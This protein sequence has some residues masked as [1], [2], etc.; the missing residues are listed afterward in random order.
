MVGCECCVR[1][2]I[3][4]RGRVGCEE[5]AEETVEGRDDE[6]VASTDACA[7]GAEDSLVETGEAGEE[8]GAPR[9]GDASL[10]CV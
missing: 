5:A 3:G 9:F 4:G 2:W 7:V 8:V 6:M 10:D 1:F